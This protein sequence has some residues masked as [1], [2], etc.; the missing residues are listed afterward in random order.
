MGNYLESSSEEFNEAAWHSSEEDFSV[1]LTVL[2]DAMIQLRVQFL[3]F[4]SIFYH[5][6]KAKIE[7]EKKSLNVIII[8]VQNQIDDIKLIVGEYFKIKNLQMLK[9]IIDSFEYTLNKIAFEISKAK[10]Q[11]FFIEKVE[12]L[13][14]NLNPFDVPIYENIQGV[15][16]ELNTQVSSMGNIPEKLEIKT[17]RETFQLEEE[18]EIRMDNCR[19]MSGQAKIYK[20]FR[21]SV[22]LFVNYLEDEQTLSTIQSLNDNQIEYTIFDVSTDS[23]IRFISKALSDCETFP[24]L[25][26]DGAFEP[27]PI[28]KNL[29]PKLPKVYTMN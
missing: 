29:L 8:V 22:V 1:K 16:L 19:M 24:Q 17:Q 27:L 18:N 23:E 25:F 13:I 2:R 20:I 5:Q 3:H 11:N 9:T 12:K 21:K 4:Q 14:N 6:N 10:G 7:H 28:L 15:V 26:V